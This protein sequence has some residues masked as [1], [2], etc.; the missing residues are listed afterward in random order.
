M[1]YAVKHFKERHAITFIKGKYIHAHLPVAV[2]LKAFLDSW[3][4]GSQDKMKQMHIENIKV[5][6]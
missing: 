5:E 3:I 4:S 6:D 1:K 2:S